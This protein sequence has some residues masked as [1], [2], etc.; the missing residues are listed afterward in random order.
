MTAV[1][2]RA[3]SIVDDLFR[4][5][6]SSVAGPRDRQI[7]GEGLLVLTCP[8]YTG[9]GRE[10]G[11]MSGCGVPVGLGERARGARCPQCGESDLR[12]YGNGSKW[13]APGV[14]SSCR[15]VKAASSP[16]GARPTWDGERRR[17]AR[18][19]RAQGRPVPAG[20]CRL[21]SRIVTSLVAR[22]RR[23][24]AKLRRQSTR[25]R[26][27]AHPGGRLPDCGEPTGEPTVTDT[28]RRQATSSQY[29]CS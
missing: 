26:T 18:G 10:P 6:D 28:E 19:G 22:C 1:G 12:P 21:G 14:A 24:P 8:P 7:A 9:G 5:T 11:T 13:P 17:Q 3:I 29:R 23:W 4:T 20:G 27:A 15:A 2:A 16:R 25:A